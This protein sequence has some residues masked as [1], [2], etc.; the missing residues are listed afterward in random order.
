[1]QKFILDNNVYIVEGACKHCIYNLNTKKLYNIDS[2]FYEQLK[3]IINPYTQ[4]Y[5]QQLL[6]V[7]IK[8]KI[9]VI[10]NLITP[11]LD[12]PDLDMKINFAWIEI[13]RNCNLRCKHCYEEAA[14]SSSDR[15][16]SLEDYNIVI[17]RLSEA[18]I[19]RIQLIGGEPFLH[20]NIKEFLI[21]GK[22]FFHSI[23]VFTNGTSIGEE[24]LHLIRQQDIHL[25]FSLY[26]C[27]PC[28]HD[29][30]T[31]TPGSFV[32]TYNNIQRAI[33]LGIKCRISSVE[34][35]GVPKF[36]IQ[37]IAV[38]HRNDYPRLSGRAGLHLYN[39]DM[40]VRKLITKNNFTRPLNPKLF[41]KRKH[42][43]NCFSNKLY[44]DV[45]L[46]IYPCVME[47]RLKHGNIFLHSIYDILDP[48][49][50][51]LNKD[52]IEGCKVCEF[53]YS[54]FDCRPD[55][56]SEDPRAKPWYCTYDPYTATWLDI[57]SFI[58][59]LWR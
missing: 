23:E 35:N 5:N 8:E 1:M 33:E 18:G 25:A 55:S 51:N 52:N 30:V 38:E 36:S 15:D 3:N 58:N 13:T 40:L 24:M 42:F 37:N 54:C 29:S 34:M 26:S 46:D 12:Y 11:K 43:H 22:T 31:L 7:L 32:K 10:N 2:I 17:D 39:R 20:K 53:R 57:D 16:L 9:I 14:N 44:I 47:R 4:S 49:V 48:K 21:K 56:R 19:D 6:D 50:T 41:I 59:D 45:N 28:L 27:N